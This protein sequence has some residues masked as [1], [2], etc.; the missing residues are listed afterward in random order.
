MLLKRVRTFCAAVATLLI[1]TLPVPLTA[2][3]VE[4]KCA[5]SNEEWLCLAERLQIRLQSNW[6]P[7]SSLPSVDRM[8]ATIEFALNSDGTLAEPPQLTNGFGDGKSSIVFENFVSA[9]KRA[10]EASQPF[11]MS[12]DPGLRRSSFR[13]EFSQGRVYIAQLGTH[14][15]KTESPVQRMRRRLAENWAVPG[16]PEELERM[17]VLLRV[18]LRPDGMLAGPPETVGGFD[19]GQSKELF[20][21][22]VRSAVDAVKATQPFALPPEK[23]QSWRVIEMNFNVREM[24]QQ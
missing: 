13:A 15:Q 20:D 22:F 21:S 9:A 7:D 18:E 23:Y 1:G 10:I 19:A 4:A 17:R 2:D 11:Q 16:P 8:S 5:D 12:L 3:A 6:Q 24:Y 14:P